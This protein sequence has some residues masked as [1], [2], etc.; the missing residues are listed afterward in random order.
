[1]GRNH[2]GEDEAIG[3][4]VDY[5]TIARLFDYENYSTEGQHT[6]I[7]GP[8]THCNVIPGLDKNVLSSMIIE[9]L[10]DPNSNGNWVKAIT[11]NS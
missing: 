7:N 3:I 1:M 10:P 9:K 11:G 6:T 2:I 5:R 4:H 8:A